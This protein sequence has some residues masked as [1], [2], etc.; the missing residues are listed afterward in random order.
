MASA[1]CGVCVLYSILHAGV[2]AEKTKVT[3]IMFFLSLQSDHGGVW[4]RQNCLQQQLQSL[5][6]IHPTSLLWG[7]KHP[8]R[9][10]HWL[11]PHIYTKLYQMHQNLYVLLW[12]YC[13]I[14]WWAILVNL[15]GFLDFLSYRFTGEGKQIHTCIW[16]HQL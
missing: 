7:R 11:Y 8:G 12:L 2:N 9:L 3:N 16:S 4:K 6:E 15:V 10:R 5:W 14:K 1:E 13:W